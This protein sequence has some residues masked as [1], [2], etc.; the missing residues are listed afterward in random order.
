MAISATRPEEQSVGSAITG[1]APP[2]VRGPTAPFP[3][4]IFLLG[5]ASLLVL[6]IGTVA[7]QIDY[8]V[9]APPLSQECINAG[10][11]ADFTGHAGV[12]HIIQGLRATEMKVVFILTIVLGLAAIVLGFSTYRKMDTRR[13]RDNAYDGAIL[14]IQAV[15]V[16]AFVWWFSASQQFLTFAK[17]DLNFAVLAGH[18]DDFLRGAKNTLVLAFGGEA[19]GIVIGLVL[20]LMVLSS[21]RVVRAPARTYINFFRG[22][23]LI[24]QLSFAYFGLFL[25]L[26][27][28]PSP[29]LAAAIVL[30]VN[31]GAYSAEVFRAGIQSIERGQVEAARGLGM[32][33]LQSMRYVVVPQAIRR[34]IPPLMNEF[35]ILIKD[36]SLVI[37]LGLA[38]SQFELYSTSQDLYSSTFSATAFV[39]VALGYLAVTLPLIALVNYVER[40]LRSGLVGAGGV[41]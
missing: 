27:W 20:S 22:T 33:Y 11:D 15:L 10:I 5:L 34:V 36:T 8:A 9:V 19:G 17:L 14:G 6:A 26:G 25:G 32:T 21:R 40:R 39:A 7:I 24:W 13:K 38:A 31:T 37:V 1:E 28:N 35:V 12:C 29:F 3:R 4:A 16:A 30:A 18:V 23:P 2:D 41:H